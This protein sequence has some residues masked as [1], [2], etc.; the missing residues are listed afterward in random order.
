MA[1]TI[2]GYTFLGPY[3]HTKMFDRDF[4]CVYILLNNLNHVVDVGQTGS[5][6]SR[7]INHERKSCW[8]KN[9]CGDTGL[10]V[11]LNQDENLRT[12]LEKLI[13]NKYQPPCGER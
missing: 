3:Y 11:C 1:I 9:G 5:I 7:I 4:A 13:R 6:N 2:E 12:L 10:Y 8:I